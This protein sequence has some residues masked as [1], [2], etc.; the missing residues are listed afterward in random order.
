MLR[1][2]LALKG[3]EATVAE[4]GLA[5]RSAWLADG[6]D[7]VLLDVMLPGIDGISLCAERRAVGDRTPVIILTAR[8]D[9]T[10]RL[11]GMA[12]GATD[13]LTK[14]FSYADLMRRIELL[15]AAGEAS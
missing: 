12:A 6:F 7:I 13:Y 1:L 15:L 3:F 2:G 4:D 10:T 5:G 9:E 14:P 11:R 8:D